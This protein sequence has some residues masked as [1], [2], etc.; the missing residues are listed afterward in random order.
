MSL[1]SNKDKG[2]IPAELKLTETGL[3]EE[4]KANQTESFDFG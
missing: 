2:F 3:T 1:Q 4:I